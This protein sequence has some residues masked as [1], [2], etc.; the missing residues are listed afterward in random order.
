MAQDAADVVVA[1]TGAVFVAPDGTALPADLVTPLPSEWVDIG[2]VSEDGVEFTFSRSQE[3]INAWQTAD[4]VRILIT[5]EPKQMAFEL[6]Q[7][8]SVTVLLAL[9]GGSIAGTAAPWTYTPPA[10]GATD[11]RAMVIDAVDG[12]YH[13]RFCFP[14]V[15]ET[16]DD[17]VF[18]LVRSDAIRLPLTFQVVASPTSWQIITDHP[19]FGTG[20]AVMGSGYGSLAA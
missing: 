8:D 4:P 12:N 10:P 17:I 11:V 13:F 14:R 16:D 6:L 2:Y 15:A 19:G 20:A 18:S 1:G 3:E 7:F 5:E 9:R